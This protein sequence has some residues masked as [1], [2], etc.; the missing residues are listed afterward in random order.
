MCYC[1][2][3]IRTPYCHNCASYM[4]TEIEEL[5][6]KLA[7]EPRV[8]QGPD[9]YIEIETYDDIE[10]FGFAASFRQGVLDHIKEKV[11]RLIDEDITVPIMH[12]KPFYL[13]P[14][15]PQAWRD[16]V[17]MAIEA[18]ERCPKYNQRDWDALVALRAL[19]D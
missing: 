7:A 2:P 14:Q 10:D 18:L 3:S 19:G 17:K 12:V 1:T 4:H 15:I 13:A 16:A 5:K 6:A 8:E 9:G 11:L